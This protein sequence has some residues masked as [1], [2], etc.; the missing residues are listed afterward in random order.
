[1]RSAYDCDVP[2]STDFEGR[3][4]RIRQR[5][6]ELRLVSEDAREEILTA[7]EDLLNRARAHSA[8]AVRQSQQ[9]RATRR[10]RR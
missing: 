7:T 1:M 2:D 6:T 4:A 5:L 3:L 8:E 9:L 10:K